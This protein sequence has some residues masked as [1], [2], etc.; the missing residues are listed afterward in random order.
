MATNNIPL[1]MR[2]LVARKY[3]KPAEYEVVDVPVPTIKRA[4]EVLIRVHA[5]GISTGDTQ[6][7]A[8]ASRF[9]SPLQP[10]I[11]L[12][13]Q[14]SGTVIATGSSVTALKPGDAVYGLAIRHGSMLASPLPGFASEYA[15]A[16]ADILLPKP[17]HISFEDAAVLAGNVTTAAQCLNRYFQLAGQPAS[18]GSLEGKT[19]FIPA[20]LSATGSVAIQ[21]VKNV[22]GAARVVS[23]VSTAKV[24]LVATY[25][26]GLI[27]TLVDYTTQNVVEAIG[28]ETVDFVYNTQWATFTSTLPLLKHHTGIA[29]SIASVPRAETLRKMFGPGNVPFIFIWIAHLANAWYAWKL[30]GTGV[31]QDFVSGN[32]GSREDLERAGEWIAAGK[33]R[34]VT[35]VV[36]LEDLS[37][38]REACG[39]VATGKGGL[40]ALVIKIV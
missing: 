20:A 19:V 4:D 13:A 22:Y 17:A 23:T 39:R 15:V 3:C 8:G 18:S 1:T 10:P 40:G 21:V 29:V 38:V 16:R 35:T 26:P 2:S 27:D 7:A 33:V 25:L 32:P 31:K 36:A 5:A 34:A 37:A 12:G 14:G 9:I 30:R 6:F 28:K 11:P 24:P